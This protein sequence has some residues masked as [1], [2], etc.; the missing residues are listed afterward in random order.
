MS[1]SLWG[2][3]CWS[4]MHVLATRIKEEDFENKK[5]SLWLV[6]NEICNNLPCPEC[7]QHAVSL[8]KQTKKASVLKSKDNLELFLFD[9]HNLVNKKKG[10]KLFTKEEYNLKY[11]KENIRDI[12]FNFINIFNASARNNNL[13]TD[14][15][16]R[17][18]F[19]QKFIAWININK[20]SFI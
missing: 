6:I 2:P 18:R 17:Q 4:L 5:E 16:H 7:R 8:M 1:K 3:P 19:I 14:A 11:K 20:E 9:F 10:L 12:V 15:F 13:M